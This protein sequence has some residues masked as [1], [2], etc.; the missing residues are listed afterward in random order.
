MTG[1]SPT[2]PDW[3]KLGQ[4]LAGEATPEEAATVK[5]WLE[6]HPQDAQLVA[7]LDAA[8][9]RSGSQ[10]PL[11]VEAALLRVK[12]RAKAQARTALWRVAGF[13]AAAAVLFVAG[14]IMSR[15]TATETPPSIARSYSTLVGQRDSVTLEDGTRITLGPASRIGVRGREV[16]LT[17]EAF[18]DV[19]HDEARPFTVRAGA[20]VIRD[21]GTEFSVHHD[22]SEP[23]RIV[24]HEGAVEV[25]AENT[26]TLHP[27][28]VAVVTLVGV[29]EASRGAATDDDLAWTQG[30]LVFRD[31]PVT[32]LEADLRRWYGVQ[33]RVTDS[34]LTR[35]HFT[36]SFIAGEPATRVLDA[37]ALALGATVERRGDTA[38]IRPSAT[39]TR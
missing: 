4:Y 12:T 11:D 26:A 24:V 7:A 33:L 34:A 35:R 32:E 3:D 9:R 8:A 6:D 10:Q 29:I 38:Y 39:P 31:A 17:G 1:P 20:V 13:V 23:V 36:G 19:E 15:R 28:D 16:S 5:R 27:G 2:S 18:F 30:R 21:I 37:I 14:V 22:P 25:M